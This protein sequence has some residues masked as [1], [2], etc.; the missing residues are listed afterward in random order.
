MVRT[1]FSMFYKGAQ[2]R[3]AGRAV[4]WWWWW[5][6]SQGRVAAWA[7]DVVSASGSSLVGG[8]ICA[9]MQNAFGCHRLSLRLDKDVSRPTPALKLQESEC[10]PTLTVTP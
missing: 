7:A 5:M 3:D 4:G 10:T 9:M 6:Q 8:A 1:A 2:G